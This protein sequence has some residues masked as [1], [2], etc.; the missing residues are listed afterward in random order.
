MLV[1]AC[2]TRCSQGHG[3]FSFVRALQSFG[4]CGRSALSDIVCIFVLLLVVQQL[5]LLHAYQEGC[6]K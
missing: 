2:L 3:F 4:R 1:S 6:L 5:R